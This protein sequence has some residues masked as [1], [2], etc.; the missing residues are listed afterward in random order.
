MMTL[1]Q[2]QPEINIFT[3][4]LFNQIFTAFQSASRT[5]TRK[6]FNT[7]CSK[8]VTSRSQ[9]E[10]SFDLIKGQPLT[11]ASLTPDIEVNRKGKTL[12]TAASQAHTVE[13][14]RQEARWECSNT[15]QSPTV[16]TGLHG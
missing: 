16:N 8:I 3:L 4:Q 7:S 13:S 11:F 10:L 15:P 5:A 1:V 6:L 12:E 14:I 9:F 2:I